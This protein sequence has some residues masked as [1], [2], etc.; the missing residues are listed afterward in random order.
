VALVNPADIGLLLGAGLS[1]TPPGELAELDLRLFGMK[2][3]A[4]T[5][6]TAGF[7]LV[8]RGGRARGW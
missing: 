4:T 5:A 7:V 2:L 3:Y 6:Q 1:N 8:G